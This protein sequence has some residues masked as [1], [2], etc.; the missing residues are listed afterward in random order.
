[1]HETAG[2][3]LPKVPHVVWDFGPSLPR[4]V[5]PVALEAQQQRRLKANNIRSERATFV[6]LLIIVIPLLST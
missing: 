2:H 1:M 3:R 6:A 5:F 4:P